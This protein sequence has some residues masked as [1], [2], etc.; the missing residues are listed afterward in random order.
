M[1]FR[2]FAC[3]LIICVGIPAL[4]VNA[5]TPDS[6]SDASLAIA[7][8]GARGAPEIRVV[9]DAFEYRQTIPIAYAADGA[10]IPPPLSWSPGPNATRSYVLIVEDPDG[11]ASAPA[12]HWLMYDIPPE[13]RTAGAGARIKQSRSFDGPSMQRG[14][15]TFG[16]VGYTGP[17]ATRGGSEHS[18]HFQVFAIDMQLRL[19]DG[20][21]LNQVLGAMRGHVLAAG[22][23]TG[24][25]KAPAS[26]AK[27]AQARA[28]EA[29]P[30]PSSKSAP[31][32]TPDAASAS[33]SKPTSAEK[34][35]AAAELT[36]NTLAP[37]VVEG[38]PSQALKP[39][40]KT[41]KKAATASAADWAPAPEAQVMHAPA[42]NPAA[43][44]R[45]GHALALSPAPKPDAETA[46]I[47]AGNSPLAPAA[48]PGKASALKSNSARVAEAAP[49]PLLD[50]QPP[51]IAGIG[52]TPRPKPA[53]ATSAQASSITPL[54]LSREVM[55][56]PLLPSAPKAAQKPGA[57]PASASSLK[58]ASKLDTQTTLAT[59]V[60]SPPGPSANAPPTPVLKLANAPVA[61][62]TA[63]PVPTP[64]LPAETVPTTSTNAKPAGETPPAAAAKSDKK[65]GA[66]TAS[67][68]LKLEAK[69]STPTASAPL[70]E[71]SPE[72][73]PDTA[74]NSSRAVVVEA[75]LPSTPQ[76]AH[77]PSA[78]PA[79]AAPLKTALSLDAQTAKAKPVKSPP[80][81]GAEAPPTAASKAT[82]EPGA[83][84]AAPLALIP[85]SK[86]IAQAATIV[87]AADPTAPEKSVLKLRAL[88]LAAPPAQSK[89]TA[90]ARADRPKSALKS[91]ADAKPPSA[92]KPAAR[93]IAQ[94]TASFALR[95][96]P[97]PQEDKPPS[98][99]LKRAAGPKPGKAAHSP[100]AMRPS[101]GAVLADSGLR[102]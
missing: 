58:T 16:K 90:E 81:S 49:T 14:T 8:L 92:R 99:A 28:P 97:K 6:D 101:S 4:V 45:I 85:A 11:S 35:R 88:A 27:I 96:G 73:S 19:P 7:R 83:L 41:T 24:T 98:G 12:V 33:A 102:P 54:K 91:V 40:S 37:P 48:E 62:M 94:K 38:A 95:P 9:S 21:A 93:P 60:K 18:Y 55:M 84:T 17:R 89:P 59:S 30:S 46:P 57:E 79:P 100:I 13:Q 86:T 72:Q 5:E 76:A 77:K 80:K 2:L 70:L 75:L 63:P 29:E 78:Q 50:P 56:E 44:S 51:A 61:E 20:A 31:S 32:S 25:F 69:T 64:K 71:F 65:A 15:N 52:P 66:A 53:S 26:A 39:D 42:S 67:L 10:N 87:A 34:I 43:K 22:E 36:P 1:W 23:L 74:P 68:S 82:P 3:V 47:I